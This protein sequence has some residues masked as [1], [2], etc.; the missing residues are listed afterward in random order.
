MISTV[1]TGHVGIGIHVGRD[2]THLA[3]SGGCAHVF[4]AESGLFAIEGGTDQSKR[5]VVEFLAPGELISDR[6][7]GGFGAVRFRAVEAGTLRRYMR[8]EW[9][10]DA[11]R[12]A[13]AGSLEAAAARIVIANAI[14]GIADI[15]KRVASFL[16]AMALRL[17]AA[18]D[19]AAHVD[20][21]L[22]RDDV[23]SHIQINPDT[24][25]RCYSRLRARQLVA[26]SGQSRL[27]V[28]DLPTLLAESPIADLIGRTFAPQS[29]PA[30]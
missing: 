7:L 17:G 3:T 1:Q 19:P 14:I 6:V 10:Q 27:V 23:A 25:S 30:G 22:S 12:D 8:T 29:R 15:D 4:E 26:R 11:P 2:H 24:L 5:R 9:L 18:R 13:L 21:P 16:G 28:L 20:V